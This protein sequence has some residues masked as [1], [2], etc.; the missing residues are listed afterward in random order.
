MKILNKIKIAYVYVND[1][2]AGELCQ[3]DEGYT[4]Q[5]YTKYLEE[6]N[7]PVSLTLGLR[8]ELFCSKT[9][10][11]FFD[12]LIPEGLMLQKVKEKWE[13]DYRDRFS[14]LMVSCN[15]PI[16]NVTVLEEKYELSTL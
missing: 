10:F 4:F 14:L 3:T 15:D 1:I 5:Y 13:L 9:L 8:E 6:H 16:G 11:S 12:G 7:K 2:Y